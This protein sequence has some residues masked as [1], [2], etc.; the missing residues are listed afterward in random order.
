V[1]SIPWSFDNAFALDLIPERKQGW[2]IL[3][4]DGSIPE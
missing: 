2:L 4:M 1:S 3:A